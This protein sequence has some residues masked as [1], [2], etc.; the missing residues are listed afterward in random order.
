[1]MSP[2]S[3]NPKVTESGYD[4]VFRVIG[5]DDQQG[6]IAGDFIASKFPGQNV[7][8]IHD[9]Q[10]YGLGLA[11]FTKKQLN[12]NGITEVIFAEFAP[13]Q[14]DYKSIVDQLVA[15]KSDVVYAGG[16]QADIGIILR[17]A[18]KHLPDLQLL[19][20]D[21]LV[22]EEFLVV[23]G[24]DGAGTYFTFG[25]D[26]RTQ[27]EAQDAVARIRD[28]DAYE[29]D[30]YTLYSYAAIQA[31]SQAVIE[32]KSTKRHS[33]INILR[34]GSFD[35]VLGKIG[36]DKNGDVTGVSAFVWYRFTDEDYVPVK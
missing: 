12:K 20:G 2:A 22:N 7:A 6:T 36:F 33:V 1:M 28:E 35:T 19:S 13:E 29:P 25:P 5:R 10:A 30:G 32:A 26:L 21:S 24:E 18:K 4:N 15:S 16:Y 14:S 27:P 31:W 11:E 3:T 8:I 34:K 23:A 17:Q 9:G